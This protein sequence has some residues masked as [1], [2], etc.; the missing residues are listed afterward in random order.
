MSD[1]QRP[2]RPGQQ[3][4]TEVEAHHHG[5]K[6]GANAEL[7]DE[8]E[9]GDEVEAHHHGHKMGANAEAGDEAESDD[10]FEAH[11]HGHKMT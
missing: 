2:G 6:M 5:H 9:G 10:D 11:S 4:E 8:A 1:E 7:G 3:D